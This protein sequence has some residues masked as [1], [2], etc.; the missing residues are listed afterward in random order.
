MVWSSSATHSSYFTLRRCSEYLHSTRK[1]FLGKLKRVAQARPT[2]GLTFSKAFDRVQDQ[3]CCSW[4]LFSSQLFELLHLQ[5]NSPTLFAELLHCVHPWHPTQHDSCFAISPSSGAL[6]AS[7]TQSAVHIVMFFGTKKENRCASLLR[8]SSTLFHLQELHRFSSCFSC[9]SGTL[10]CG[11]H[12]I[13]ILLLLFCRVVQLLQDR[14]LSVLASP[15]LTSAYSLDIALPCR[16]ADA[17]P[18]PLSSRLANGLASFSSSFRICNPPL[19][20]A[21]GLVDLVQ[22]PCT[23]IGHV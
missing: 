1:I 23:C 4:I 7:K 13:L 3:R 17:S 9:Q 15:L 20:H 16:I 2:G 6:R 21:I 19:L 8:P 11:S 18:T 5:Q 10:G 12:R 22:K 14:F